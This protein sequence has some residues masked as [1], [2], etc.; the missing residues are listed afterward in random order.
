MKAR[1]RVSAQMADCG[2]A[3]E[4]GESPTVYIGLLRLF[5][6]VA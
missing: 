3:F 2:A 4:I 6:N 5:K 1:A